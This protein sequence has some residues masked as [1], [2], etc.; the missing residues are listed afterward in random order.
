MA[1]GNPSVSRSFLDYLGKGNRAL[2]RLRDIRQLPAVAE[3]AYDQ[4]LAF[5]FDRTAEGISILIFKRGT[6]PVTGSL[7]DDGTGI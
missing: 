6:K 4:T 7:D 2:L 5:E 1:T 3:I